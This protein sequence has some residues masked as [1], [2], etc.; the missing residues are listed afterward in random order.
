[1]PDQLEAF[2]GRLGG[3]ADPVN[4]MA[5]SCGCSTNLGATDTFQTLDATVAVSRMLRQYTE[6]SLLGN[7]LATIL[8]AR[9]KIPCAVW[10]AYGQ[11]R[12]D[13]LVKSQELLDQLAK[14]DITIEQTVWSQGKPV[15]SATNP[16]EVKTVRIQ[17]PLRPPAFA[18]GAY[19]GCTGISQMYGALGGADD[20]TSPLGLGAVPIAIVAPLVAVCTAATAGA[21]IALIAAGSI[22]VGIVGYAAYKSVQQVAVMMREYQSAPSKTIA[23]YTDCVT[24]LVASGYSQADASTRC[25]GSQVSAQAYAAERGAGDSWSSWTWALIGLGV[26]VGGFAVW[27]LTQ[28]RQ[29]AIAGIEHEPQALPAMKPG[30]AILMGDLYFHPRSR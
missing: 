19:A 14:Q 4:Q 6:L 11:A 18:T 22:V 7:K 10:T 30:K 23:A 29:S 21:C 15:M 3:F 5:A 20:N 26:V 2:L 13:Y 27:K 1:M 25:T 9:G 24:K 8:Q 17:A 28:P 12:Q 16:N